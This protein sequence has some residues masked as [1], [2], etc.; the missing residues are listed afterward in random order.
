MMLYSTHKVEYTEGGGKMTRTIQP[1]QSTVV[2][3]L[4]K[5]DELYA[6]AKVWQGSQAGEWFVAG[7]KP[8]SVYRVEIISGVPVCPCRGMESHDCC[9]H[10]LLTAMHAGMIPEPVAAESQPVAR[11]S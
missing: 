11:A 5:A 10:S 9:Y 7:S 2:K 1:K 4:R 8:G 3:S 6:T